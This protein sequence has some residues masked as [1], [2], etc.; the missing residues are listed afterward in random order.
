[1]A[2]PAALFALG[3]LRCAFWLDVWLRL[4][5]FLG[6][7]DFAISLAG[8]LLY[9]FATWRWLLVRDNQHTVGSLVKVIFLGLALA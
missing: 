9:D 7:R 1:M 2:Q 6:L 3:R 4:T 8:K 5:E